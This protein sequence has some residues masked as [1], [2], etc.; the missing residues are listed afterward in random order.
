MFRMN[1]IPGF[2]IRLCVL[3]VMNPME[4]R[5]IRPGPLFLTISYFNLKS[6]YVQFNMMEQKRKFSKH[7][8]E[9]NMNHTKNVGEIVKAKKKMIIFLWYHLFTNI[10]YHTVIN[11]SF[12]IYLYLENQLSRF[13][14]FR[15]SNT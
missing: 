8:L 7:Q 5:D 1:C 15:V 9:C 12:L 13:P 10:G 2:S 3:F 11:L 6:K 4:R 14:E